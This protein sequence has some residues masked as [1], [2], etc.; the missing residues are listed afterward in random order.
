M[1]NHAPENYNCPI[2]LAV[3]GVENNEG[4]WIKQDDIFYRDDLVMG[5]ISSKAIKGNN[6]HP[7]VVPL[8]HFE[9]IY[10]L[11]DGLGARIFEIAKKTAIALKE[12][13]ECDGVTIM[14]NNEPASRQH[15]FHYHMHVI[16]RF[17]DDHFYE[18][19][20]KSEKSDPSTRV[21]PAADLREYF[22]KNV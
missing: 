10:E 15:A 19:L 1:H 6:A 16:P 9:N 13:R 17:N 11:P 3:K 5:F 21:K 7:L 14:Q 4:V 18:E 22:K 2:C 8:E 20:L 12:I